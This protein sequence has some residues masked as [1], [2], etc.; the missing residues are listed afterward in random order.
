MK[1]ENEN[2]TP[3]AGRKRLMFSVFIALLVGFSSYVFLRAQPDGVPDIAWPLHAIR[4]WFGGENPYLADGYPY[5]TPLYYPLPSLFVL[6]PFAFLPDAVA[7][8]IFF[9]IS[10]G[11][12]AWAL[13]ENRKHQ[14][15]VFASA[16]FFAAFALMQWSPL[17]M[18]IYLL[19]ALT[20]LLICKPNL[21]IFVLSRGHI[22][23]KHVVA[24]AIIL[25]FSLILIPQW[26]LQWIEN[27]RQ[28]TPVA[29][30][31]WWIRLI[32][33]T[34]LF[35]WKDPRARIVALLGVVPHQPYDLIFLWLVPR[36]LRESLVLTVLSWCA[37]T[38][39]LFSPAYFEIAFNT[40]IYLPALAMVLQPAKSESRGFGEI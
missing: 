8:P 17:M 10:C 11:L 28:Y 1:T 22:R 20:P 9:G 26:P 38:V 32:L 34:A 19:P 5:G 4:V 21:G 25:I 16:P 2:T 12:L 13:H 35:N 18:A 31:F 37:F 33:L 7:A 24:I 40:L 30:Q 36:T 39:W 3:V 29:T 27:T 23:K 15:L 14:L 6:V